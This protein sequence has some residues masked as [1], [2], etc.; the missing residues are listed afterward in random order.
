ML[1]LILEM[2]CLI[3]LLCLGKSVG[4]AR[5]WSV[6]SYKPAF[7]VSQVTELQN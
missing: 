1:L 2:L 4:R 6:C 7:A 5:V 3:T